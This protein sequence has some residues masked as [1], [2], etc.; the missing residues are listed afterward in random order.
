MSLWGKNDGKTAAG[1]I[2]IAANGAV[3]GSS[4]AFSTAAR[5]GD[6]IRSGGEDYLISA[7]ASNTAATVIAGVPGATLTAVGSGASYTL[8]EKCK[9]VTTSEATSTNGI[10]GDPTKVFGVDT[11]EIGAGGD[12]VV[13]VTIVDGGSG[14]KGSAPSVS[15]S[16]GGGSSAAA[17]AGTGGYPSITSVAVTNVGSGY[18]STPTVAI[19]PPAAQTFNGASSVTDGTDTIT[20][21]AHPFLTGDQVTYGDN[22]G[23]AVTGLTN[24]GT[25]FV[26]KTAANTLKLATTKA[27]A[28]AGT[29]IDITSGSGAGHTLTGE[30]ATATASRGASSS[31]FHAGWV[32]R[33]VGTGGRAGRIQYETLVASSSIAGDQE[34][35]KELPDS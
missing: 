9:F 14:Y 4:T 2:A 30:T 21:S 25:F 34:D 26:I 12:N 24:G 22:G 13:S 5:V 31:G 15:F 20:I 23:T 10:H 27:N 8:S 35:D 32:R 16:G 28:L 3:T 19:A 6:Y 29:A 1:T 17:T 7:I 18:T 33:T 11:T